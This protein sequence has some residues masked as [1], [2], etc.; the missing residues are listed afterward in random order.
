MIMEWIESVL[1]VCVCILLVGFACSLVWELFHDDDILI[2][3]DG[4]LQSI[5]DCPRFVN[6]NHVSKDYFKELLEC[7]HGFNDENIRYLIVDELPAIED[8]E[9]RRTIYIVVTESKGV[10]WKYNMYTPVAGV[11]YCVETCT[12][13]SD[14]LGK[15]E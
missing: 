9:D 14:Y 11:W 7:L 10:L 15:V 5:K 2:H 4:R 8:V 12:D 13:M 1:T 6:V 3:K